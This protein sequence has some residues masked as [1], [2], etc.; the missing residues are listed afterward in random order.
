MTLYRSKIK[1]IIDYTGA[2][3]IGIL[4]APL[5]CYL[6]FKVKRDGGPAFYTQSRIGKDGKIFQ[7]WKFRTMVVGADQVLQE[8]L[9][10]DAVARQEWERDFKLK[11]DPRITPIGLILRKTSLDEL[12]QLLNILRGEM[13]L[14]GPRPVTAAEESYYGDYFRDYLSIR[15]GMTG[16]WQISGRNDISYDQ[17]VQMDSWYARNLSFWVDLKILFATI[18]VVLRRKGSY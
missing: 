9:A 2:A 4:A 8:I 5:L 12:P 1:P 14:V 11:N 17:R 6:I 10:K 3:T 18:G 7:C 13:S 15:P 16:L